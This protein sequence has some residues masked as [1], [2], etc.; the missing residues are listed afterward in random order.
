VLTPTF[1]PPILQKFANSEIATNGHS[2]KILFRAMEDTQNVPVRVGG[3]AIARGHCHSGK[4]ARDSRGDGHAQ[5]RRCS[6]MLH[7]IGANRSSP[8]PTG[9]FKIGL[10][11]AHDDNFSTSGQ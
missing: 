10:A 11:V 3:Q 8:D 2:P 9:N 4:V 7:L 6:A 1:L 5:Q